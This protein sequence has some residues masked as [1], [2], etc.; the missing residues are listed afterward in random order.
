MSSSS[1]RVGANYVAGLQH[2]VD[3]NAVGTI[4]PLIS[5]LQGGVGDDRGESQSP[6]MPLAARR[7]EG[8][9]PLTRTRPFL[10]GGHAPRQ[11]TSSTAGKCGRC[12]CEAAALLVSDH[13]PSHM[14]VLS[15]CLAAMAVAAFAATEKPRL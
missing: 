7:L 2:N 4:F 5:D 12:E 3:I 8:Q 1:L 14:P 13:W 9:S 6:L 10:S 15:D 11:V